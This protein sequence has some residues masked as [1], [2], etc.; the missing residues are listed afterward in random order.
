MA[1]DEADSWKTLFEEEGFETEVYLKGM[2]ENDE[3]A[4]IYVEHTREVLEGFVE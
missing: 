2:G 3:I 4:K 1:G